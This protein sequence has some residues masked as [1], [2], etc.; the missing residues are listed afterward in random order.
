MNEQSTLTE[1]DARG[2]PCPQP[3][4]AAKRALESLL[5]GAVVIRVD[6]EVAKENILKFAR[7]NNFTTEVTATDGDYAITVFKGK[8]PP[9][10]RQIRAGEE[11]GEVLTKKKPASGRSG[12]DKG[13]KGEADSQAGPGTAYLITQDMLGL[14]ARQ[15]GEILIKSML[16]TLSER[17]TPPPLIVLVNSGVNLV[18]DRSPVIGHLR[19]LAENGCRILACGTCLEYYN[20]KDQLAVGEVTNMYSALEELEK[21]RVITV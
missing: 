4:F 18:T 9:P 14:G 13:G 20:I 3:V 17:D 21:F 12:R 10:G 1:V 15:L 7:A 5:A 8:M 19:R 11:G 2:L 6:N 16:F